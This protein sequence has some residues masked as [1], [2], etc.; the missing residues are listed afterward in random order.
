MRPTPKGKV[1]QRFLLFISNM[2]N[3]LYIFYLLFSF[4]FVT[5]SRHDIWYLRQWEV[6]YGKTAT[7]TM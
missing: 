7:I 6:V 1:Y 5:A 4:F 2:I 3:I